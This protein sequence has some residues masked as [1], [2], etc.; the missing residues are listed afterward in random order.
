[1]NVNVYAV[2]DLKIS[3]YNHPFY[4]QTHGS[5]IRAFADHCKDPQSMPHKHPE[6]FV[7]YYIGSFDDTDAKLTSCEPVELAKATDHVN[8]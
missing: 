7:L 8:A 6:D 3:A 4:S 5:A 1:M 2:R